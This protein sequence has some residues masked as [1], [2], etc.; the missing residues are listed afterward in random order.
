VEKALALTADFAALDRLRATI[1]P[2]FD[3]SPYRDEVGFT[4]R[5]EGDYRRMFQRWLDKAS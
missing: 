5:L 3:A 1:R 2:A 4:R